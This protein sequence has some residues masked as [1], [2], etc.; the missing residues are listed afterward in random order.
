MD[1]I[2]RQTPHLHVKPQDESS[3][4]RAE[5]DLPKM[6]NIP[7]LL[8]RDR[9]KG[10]L[11]MASIRDLG[12]PMVRAHMGVRSHRPC[13]LGREASSKS[14]L[15]GVWVSSPKAEDAT[16]KSISMVVSAFTKC[17]Q[18]CLWRRQEETTVADRQ[19]IIMS[20]FVNCLQVQ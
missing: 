3:A 15:K 12:N 4:D 9:A 19:G 5:S 20:G 7:Q 17:N 11:Q 8:P 16:E 13:S 18:V 1:K 10:R 6:I 14:S 2:R